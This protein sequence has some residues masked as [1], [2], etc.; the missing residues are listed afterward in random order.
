MREITAAFVS[1]LLVACTQLLFKQAIRTRRSNPGGGWFSTVTSLLFHPLVILGLASNVLGAICWLLALSRLDLSF[2]FPLLSLNYLL[3]PLGAAVC[4]GEKISPRRKMA[5]ALI[6]VG[7][8]VSA[9]G[10]T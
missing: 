1:I 9:L 3:V 4:F 2:L 8:L 5:I 7:V 10:G 6:C